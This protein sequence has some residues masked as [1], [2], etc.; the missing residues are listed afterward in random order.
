MSSDLEVA[1]P[2]LSPSDLA[3]LTPRGRVRQVHAG[4][5]LYAEGDRSNS[6]F[7]VLQGA[8]EATESSRGA[9]HILTTHRPEQF[10]GDVDVLSGR[11]LL[12]TG[13][14]VEDVSVLQLTRTPR[15]SGFGTASSWIAGDSY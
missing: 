13:R 5:T 14:V 9:P 4:E 7:V 3:A 11:A 1:F 8:V 15:P 2:V 6:F 10:T 12:V